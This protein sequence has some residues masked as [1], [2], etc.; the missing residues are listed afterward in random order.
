MPVNRPYR[1]TCRQ[2]IDGHYTEGGR[3]QY[4]IHPKYAEA[5]GHYVRAFLLLLKDLYELFDYIEPADKN[6]SCYS[7]RIHA[8]LLRACVEME[9]NCKAILKENGYKKDKEMN[10][11]D[12]KKINETHRLSSYKVKIPNWNGSASVR[13]PFSGWASGGSLPWYQAYNLIKH[14]R[15]KE[16][17][18]ATFEN[19]L[20]ASCGLL[21]LL[22][23]QFETNDFSPCDMLLSVWG[24]NDGMKSGI[25]GFFRVQ[26]PNDWPDEMKYD[27]NWNLIKNDSDPF[28]NID[29]Y[30]IA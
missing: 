29:Y 2:F 14:D 24:L 28:A 15:H 10:I 13:E 17:E 3:W 19:L 27:F 5:P 18:E 16:F 7:Y 21:V 22:S 11:G 6:L 25:G 20:D 12:Y 1:R 23:S 8:L 30:N 26:F 9:A 4:M